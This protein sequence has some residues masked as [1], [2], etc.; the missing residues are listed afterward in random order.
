MDAK[1]CGEEHSSPAEAEGH[2]LG[3]PPSGRHAGHFASFPSPLVSPPLSLSL[4][5]TPGTPESKTRLSPLGVLQEA[6]SIGK[7]F[8]LFPAP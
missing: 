5:E 8:V 1:V 3:E 7:N 2:H 4:K 6:S